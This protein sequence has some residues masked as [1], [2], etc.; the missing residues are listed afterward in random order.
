MNKPN[1]LFIC[2]D[3]QR[4]DSLGCYGNQQVRSPHIDSIATSGVRFKRHITPMQ[5]CSPSRATMITGLYP[6]NHQLITNGKALP[7]SIPTLT[8]TLADEGYQTHSVGKQHLQPLLAPAK[9]N[10][11]DSRAFW[12]KPD[13]TTWNGLI[14]VIKPST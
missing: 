10:M 3:Q 9:L 5:I 6:R 8:Q 11:P 1:I 4:S 12:E 2:T 7:E 14:M 13:A